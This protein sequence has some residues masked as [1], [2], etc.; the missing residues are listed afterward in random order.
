[1]AVEH[2]NG[3]ADV[4]LLGGMITRDARHIADVKTSQGIV[5]LYE[6]PAPFHEFITHVGGR[7]FSINMISSVTTLASEVAKQ[8]ADAQVTGD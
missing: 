1:M 2:I 6:R 5:P 8:Q 3:W 7:W 4:S